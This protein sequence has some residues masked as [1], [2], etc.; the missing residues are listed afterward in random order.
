MTNENLSAIVFD[1]LFQTYFGGVTT[2]EIRKYTS[3]GTDPVRLTKKSNLK[4]WSI[5]KEIYFQTI[6]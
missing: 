3:Y 4:R 5:F 6:E 2:H 1:F